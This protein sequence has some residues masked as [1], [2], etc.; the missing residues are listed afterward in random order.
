MEGLFD[1]RLARRGA[2]AAGGEPDD[3]QRL[4]NDEDLALLGH[5]RGQVLILPILALGTIAAH[6]IEQ[7]APVHHRSVWERRHW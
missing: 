7:S 2:S 6:L 3:V 1:C 4:R 5:S